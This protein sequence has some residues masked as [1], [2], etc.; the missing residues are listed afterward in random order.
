MLAPDSTITDVTSKLVNPIAYLGI[1]LDR[2]VETQRPDAAVRIGVTG[3]GSYP[4]YRIVRQ[5][6]DGREVV[7]GAFNDNGTPFETAAG[8]RG[9]ST[10]TSTRDQVESLLAELRS[11]LGG[12]SIS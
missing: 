9:W 1:M 8:S 2:L 3:N 10:A 6:P 4:F 7:L 12:E 5:A 11:K